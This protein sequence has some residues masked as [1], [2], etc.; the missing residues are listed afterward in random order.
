MQ[1]YYDAIA[2][3]ITVAA[4]SVSISIGIGCAL[5][6]NAIR[7]AAVIRDLKKDA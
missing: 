7:V 4:L 3:A 5:I 2:F 1:Q 6:A